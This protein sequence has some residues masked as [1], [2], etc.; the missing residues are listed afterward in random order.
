MYLNH[1][2]IEVAKKHC[3]HGYMSACTSI[4]CDVMGAC[5]AVKSNRAERRCIHLGVASLFSRTLTRG[6]QLD[7]PELQL[8]LL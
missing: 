7:P 5:E 4:T 3:P 2:I 8:P 6:E 1:F